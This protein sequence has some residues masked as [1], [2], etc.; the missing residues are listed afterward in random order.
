MYLW[1]YGSMG[2][3]DVATA[4]SVTNTGGGEGGGGR[5]TAKWFSTSRV[6]SRVLAID[7]KRYVG[8]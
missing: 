8:V 1:I 2:L 3:V 6:A 5:E 4:L 7:R